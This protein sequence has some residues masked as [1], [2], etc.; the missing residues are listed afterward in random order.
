[1]TTH[2]L[3]RSA[4]SSTNTVTA[5]PRRVE[6][7]VFAKVTKVLKQI[8]GGGT[9][10]PGLLASA[11]HDNRRLWISIATLVADDGNQL[12]PDLRARLFYLSEFVAQHSTLV[13]KNEATVDA[14]IDINQAIMAGLSVS[15]Q[16]K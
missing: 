14:L 3:A 13:L 16:I 1:M 2:A 4:Y 6:Y 12:T 9:Y 5:D 11:I 15:E 7:A 8:S 10:R